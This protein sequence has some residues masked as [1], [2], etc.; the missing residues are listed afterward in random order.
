MCQNLTGKEKAVSQV[1][2]K[3]DHSSQDDEATNSHKDEPEDASF[4]GDDNFF[5]V[6]S[7][8]IYHYII[9]LVILRRIR[10]VIGVVKNGLSCQCSKSHGRFIRTSLIITAFG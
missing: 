3:E 8:V 7:F 5:R 6:I 10:A 2:G 1:E 4:T 9:I